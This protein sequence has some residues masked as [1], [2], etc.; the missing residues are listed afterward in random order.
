[1]YDNKLAVAIKSAGRVLREF[2]DTVYLPFGCEYSVLI[3]NLN[4]VRA[5]VSVYIDGNN[6]GDGKEFIIQPN[7]EL[8]LERSIVNGNL[9]KGNRFK[10]IERTEQIEQHRGVGVD[11]GIVRVEFDFEKKQPPI[12]ITPGPWDHYP[13]DHDPY[14]PRVFYT[15]SNIDPGNILR[16]HTSVPTKGSSSGTTSSTHNDANS[17]ISDVGITVPG[18]VSNQQFTYGDHFLTENNPRVIILK[19]LGKTEQDRVVQ[20]PVTVKAKPKCVT[21]GRVNKATSKFCAQCGTSLEIV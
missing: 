21:C 7:S 5:V 6:A 3:K 11:D 9:N 8:E 13:W 1:M 12:R 17:V 4:T 20:Q 15:A 2:K 16:S 18:S 10:F 19:L 14:H